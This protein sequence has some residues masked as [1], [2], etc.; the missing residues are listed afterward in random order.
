[1]RPA[2]CVVILPEAFDEALQLP[3]PMRELPPALL[4]RRSKVAPLPGYWTPITGKLEHDEAPIDGARREACEETGLLVDPLAEVWGC[5]TSTGEFWLSWWLATARIDDAIVLKQD[6]VDAA[7][8]VAPA[9]ILA[10][11]YTP[12]FDDTI[13]F[14]SRFAAVLATI[15]R[16]HA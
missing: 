16:P 8:W 5:P 9:D 13:E 3:P 1:M 10:R 12:I 6:E 7:K 15:E 2:V 11:A 14:F 4:V